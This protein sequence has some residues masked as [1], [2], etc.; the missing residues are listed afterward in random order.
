MSV[1]EWGIVVGVIVSV[2]LAVLP[3]TLMVHSKLAVVTA[4]IQSLEAKVDRLID[5]NEQ[6]SPLCAVHTTRLDVFE[7]RL[8][9]IQERLERLAED[10]AH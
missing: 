7:A 5:T 10:R 4:K 8:T 9:A 1:Q 6:R 3:W 2:L